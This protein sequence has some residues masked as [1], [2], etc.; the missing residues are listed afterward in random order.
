MEAQ[1]K[2]EQSSLFHVWQLELDT[3]SICGWKW[4]T[5]WPFKHTSPK[6]E[7]NIS[8]IFNFIVK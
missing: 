8:N 4:N 2:K 7:G 3:E 5:A 1:Q 6:Q